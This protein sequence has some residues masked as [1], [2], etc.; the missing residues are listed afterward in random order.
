MFL[1]RVGA[2]FIVGSFL[3][4][5]AFLTVAL[6]TDSFP[7]QAEAVNKVV[8]KLL[9]PD[10]IRH[11]D[12]SIKT[13]DQLEWSELFGLIEELNT[14]VGFIL[15]DLKPDSTNAIIF[16]KAI[17]YKIEADY[18]QDKEKL[19]TVGLT[20]CTHFCCGINIFTVELVKSCFVNHTKAKV[21]VW[22]ELGHVVGLNHIKDK[23]DIMNP[24]LTKV[25]EV[26]NDEIENAFLKRL[27]ER[28]GLKDEQQ[29]GTQ[30]ISN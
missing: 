3:F 12:Y 18:S 26:Y 25:I 30:K 10:A 2:F 13:E 4:V 9:C 7:A 11:Y 5:E 1:K 6:L 21:L 8:D 15:F 23:L 16:Q 14:K 19:V 24:V 20:H 27:K 29:N 28:M 17:D 22:H